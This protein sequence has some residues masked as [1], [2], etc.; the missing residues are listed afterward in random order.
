MEKE[1]LNTAAELC[2][3]ADG[4]SVRPQLL[5]AATWDARCET[6]IRNLT[7][8]LRHVTLRS[9][10]VDGE[11]IVFGSARTETDIAGGERIRL[12]QSVLCYGICTGERYTMVT[13]LC[14][15]DRVISEKH[16]GF[17]F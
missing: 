8:S 1:E 7:D 11:G 15:R 10:I 3:A 13:E 14:D 17:V 2:I 12:V 5:A 6:D 9:S 4:V 16:T